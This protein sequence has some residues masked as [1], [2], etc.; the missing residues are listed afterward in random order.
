MALC[1]GAGAL[2]LKLEWPSFIDGLSFSRVVRLDGPRHVAFLGGGSFT[3]NDKQG[4]RSLV[5]TPAGELIDFVDAPGGDLASMVLGSE[6][7]GGVLL[8][9]IAADMT[10]TLV[11]RG[12]ALD[13]VE[14]YRCP[15]AP[16]MMFDLGSGIL[17]IDERPGEDP[18]AI[19]HYFL[20]LRSP[21]GAPSA[22]V[23]WR[24]D[25]YVSYRFRADGSLVG[26][27][28]DGTVERRAD[29]DAA[30]VAMAEGLD[31][32]YPH[33]PFFPGGTLMAVVDRMARV[34]VLPADGGPPRSVAVEPP[35]GSVPTLW[36]ADGGPDGSML[37]TDIDGSAVIMVAPDGTVSSLRETEPS[38]AVAAIRGGFTACAILAILGLA[39]AAAAS[40]TAVFA[41][42]KRYS[43]KLLLAF[44]LLIG[45]SSS[46]GGLASFLSARSTAEAEI[47]KGLLRVNAV[48]RAFLPADELAGLGTGDGEP[49]E[50]RR[51]IDGIAAALELYP[52]DDYWT[53]MLYR[54]EEGLWSY[55]DESGDFVTFIRSAPFLDDAISSGGLT[56]RR[57][58][59]FTGE[60]MSVLSPVE[61]TGFEVPWV[62]ETYVEASEVDGESLRLALRAALASAAIALASALVMVPLSRALSRTLRFLRTG[63]DRV[64]SG[65]YSFRIGGTGSDEMGEVSRAFDA[66]AERIGASLER[67]VALA[68][69]GS[70]FVPDALVETLGKRDILE[71][72]LGDQV[73]RRMT[74]LFAD[75]VGFTT[76]SEGMDPAGI[77]DFVNAY[78]SRMGP[79][80]RRNCGFVDKYI[81]DAIMALF[82][83]SP[84]DAVAT[85]VDIL[86]ELGAMNRERAAAGLPA[87]EAGIGMH[88]G[89]L[90]LGIIGE[91]G[92]WEGTVLSDAVNLASRL[93]GL[94]RLYG[95]RALASA[96]CVGSLAQGTATRFVDVVRVKGRQLPTRVYEILPPHDPATR[97]RLDGEAAYLEAFAA[98]QA[99]EFRTA[100]DGFAA[101][102][103]AGDPAAAVLRDRCGAYLDGGAPDGFDGAILIHEK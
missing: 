80:V 14:L 82:P 94:T 2:L 7:H 70:R 55:V 27:R 71:V 49:G 74:V 68:E 65:D 79:L 44:L 40:A 43:S 48:A 77:F 42:G 5:L 84:D 33:Y 4:T 83:G 25:G 26:I 17:G 63:A 28:D 51:V 88:T 81:G 101:L 73:K 76:M 85:A 91:E 72:S 60:Y 15:Y 31:L 61:V 96:E 8:A 9:R 47:R 54:Y 10:V 12:G 98:Y 92:R 37:L 3:V 6:P 86:A 41:Y 57:Y 56:Y 102:A 67:A 39:G 62:L 38:F 18:A 78:L 100:A 30:P 52:E 36:S 45:L 53:V 11:R 50:I 87:V 13:G 64:A 89:D 90:M 24:V 59:D 32:Y 22:R 103:K 29:P 97:S 34:V 93:E 23:A 66:M 1:S 21:A 69:A 75:I 58:A 35:D 16:G 19:E 95:V 99:G 46:A 20:D